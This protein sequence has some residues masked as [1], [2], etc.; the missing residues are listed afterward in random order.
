MTKLLE[1]KSPIL[2]MSNLIDTG[3]PNR[4]LW[5]IQRVGANSDLLEQCIILAKGGR[6]KYGS[7]GK[8]HNFS[9]R[10]RSKSA[11]F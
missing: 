8:M 7:F 5:E 11:C 9:K 4:L 1:V 3:V 2:L 10:G 6:S